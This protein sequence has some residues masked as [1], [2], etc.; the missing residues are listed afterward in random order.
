MAVV[1]MAAIM[2]PADFL[3]THFGKSDYKQHIEI[4][5]LLTTSAALLVLCEPYKVHAYLE[6]HDR[7]LLVGNL[8][9]LLSITTFVAVFSFK[10]DMV[11]ISVGVLLSSLLVYVYFASGIG[12]R[13]LVPS[14]S[15]SVARSAVSEK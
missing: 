8:L 2:L 14:Q 6:R 4:L 3:L 5:Y 1:T 15:E 11:W 10:R 13:L 9:H 12:N 7:T